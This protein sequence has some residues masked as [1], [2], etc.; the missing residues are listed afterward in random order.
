MEGCQPWGTLS[1]TRAGWYVYSGVALRDGHPAH[2]VPCAPMKAHGVPTRGDSRVGVHVAH[3]P[4]KHG[5]TAI[6]SPG[7]GIRPIVG[8]A[9]GGRNVVAVV[10]QGTK[11]APGWRLCGG[12]PGPASQA[13]GT[14]TVD[15]LLAF[16]H[17]C[18]TAGDS[19]PRGPVA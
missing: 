5:P 18:G 10:G 3:S 14:P 9:H 6:A 12:L 4:H 15:R 11:L 19:G 7:F 1:L 17:G 2:P 16:A 13:R 8:V